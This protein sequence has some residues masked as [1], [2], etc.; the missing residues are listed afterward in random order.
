MAMTET[1]AIDIELQHEEQ[2]KQQQQQQQQPASSEPRLATS[3]VSPL[4]PTTHALP[5]LSI[6]LIRPT[7][8]AIPVELLAII[9]SNL[10]SYSLCAMQRIDRLSQRATQSSPDRLWRS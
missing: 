2:Q 9:A 8:R 7:W 5:I 3:S 6:P 10:D 4:L 1:W